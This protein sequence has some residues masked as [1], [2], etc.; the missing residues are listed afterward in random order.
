MKKIFKLSVR[1]KGTKE[2]FDKDLGPGVI[3]T[4][5]IVYDE[6]P[7]V[8]QRTMFRMDLINRRQEMMDKYVEVLIEE[9]EA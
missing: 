7:S 5:E 3:A 9:V 1:I 6:D 8:Y 2:V 4:Q